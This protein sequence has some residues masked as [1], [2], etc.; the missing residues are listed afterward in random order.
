MKQVIYKAANRLLTTEDK[1]QRLYYAKR[2]DTTPLDPTLVLYETRDGNSIVDSPLA[3]FMYL[4][5][6]PQ[7][8]QLKHVW[9]INPEADEDA[10]KTSLP[11]DLLTKVRFVTRDTPAYFDAI[12]SA[13]YLINNSTFESF[14][15]KRPGQVYINTWHGTPLKHMGFDTNFP[16]DS[17]KNVIRNLLMAD[18]ILSPNAHTSN[19]FIDGYRLR[20]NYPGEI[21]E[22]G[23]PRIDRTLNSDPAK[24][25]AALAKDG[26]KLE[27]GKPILLYT[28]TW[29]GTD[30]NSASDDI[31]Q[32]IKEV[33]TIT[34][35]FHDQ[36]NVLVKVHPFAYEN[37][38]NDPQVAGQLVSNYFD[39][40]E[41]LAV[42]DVLI[43]DYSSIFFDFM[44]TDK[45]I[46]F[47]A[48][49]KDLYDYSRGMY[50]DQDELPG[51]TAENITQLLAIIG[52][53]AA[54]E[55]PYKDKY[56]QMKAKIVPYD[57]GDATKRYVDYI[58]A[59]TPSDQ[60]TIRQV[61]STKQK[62]LF[63]AG[64]MRSNG[65]TT[66]FLNLTSNLDY[67]KYDVT[68][69]S[70][71]PNNQ[72]SRANIAAVDPHV[73]LMFRFGNNIMTRQEDDLD[74]YF[75]ANGVKVSERDKYPAR[76]YA[77]EMQRLTAN[78]HFDV[79]IDFSGYSYF[80]GR[81][82][83]G[84]DA[85]H[86]VA[87]MHNDLWADAHREVDGKM[88][89]LKDLM[90]MFSLYYQFDKMLSVS[91][92][93]RDVNTK[94]LAA[95]IR[96]EQM[97]YVLNTINIKR[98]LAQPTAP[99]AE[100]DLVVERADLTVTTELT[101]PLYENISA[102]KT[103]T[104]TSVTIPANAAITQFASFT[105]GEDVYVKVAIAAQYVG[106]I[107]QRELV[108]APLRVF[109]V[110]P[111]MG[112]G[113]VSRGWWK[114][115]YTDIQSGAQPLAIHALARAFMHQYLLITALANTSQGDYY[116]VSYLGK[117]LGWV[118]KW[119]LGRVHLFASWSPLYAY[120]AMRQRQLDR[121][122]KVGYPDSVEAGEWYFT[123]G[124]TP[125]KVTIWTAPPATT[126]ATKLATLDEYHD[127]VFSATEIAT[128]GEHQYVTLLWKG[129][130]LGVVDLTGLKA[131]TKAEYQARAAQ[132]DMAP[133][134]LPEV[135]LAGQ[136][137][138]PFE[139]HY[140]NVVNMG[141]LSPEKNQAA[142]LDGFA[143]FVKQQPD[144][145]LYLMGKGPLADDLAKQLDRLQLR[146]KVFLLGHID[147]PYQLMKQC[148]LFILPSLYEGQP[149][150]LL[151]A[152]TL[153]MRVLA[154]KIPANVQ[155]VGEDERYGQLIDGTT[156]AAIA[157]ALQRVVTTPN[158]FTPFDYQAY[159][160]TAV[161]NFYASIKF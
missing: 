57:D 157:A 78:L 42:V 148:D 70:N 110:T 24:V 55:A 74:R 90:G 3:M 61:D 146:G 99:E 106:W 30:V 141:R 63:Y 10:I 26:V 131:I 120:F 14:F 117:N 97:D 49:D 89:I 80:W 128:V 136:Q 45:P 115:I 60:I 132:P 91:P 135:D 92:M 7:Y 36:Y 134:L 5:T 72:D 68:L 104:A 150:V 138:M 28:P 2:F 140:F 18:Y 144:S 94:K 38:K 29:K 11:A 100:S 46:I 98:I 84:A 21:L 114:P 143:Q 123:T 65:I 103:G 17:S 130:G 161:E 50:F 156:P 108:A 15:T 83:L 62:L 51:P 113:T 4:A 76:G 19:I 77:R 154:S 149:M 147:G 122:L 23:Y 52:D 79:A 112:A 87:F 111:M 39:P 129:R 121:T 160:T 40:N 20:G 43:T 86:R 81:H 152:L 85:A 153:G 95:Y 105:Q 66:S 25:L 125:A 58:F 137:V 9:V 88:P 93:T 151:E 133:S 126:D 109:K 8:A 16:A 47:Y 32:I 159:N 59:G 102:I 27:P 101:T 33:Q 142:L 41:L 145:R 6:Q 12:L 44:V 64:G 31:A 116:Q 34:A 75:M 107:S 56:A 35:K 82:I 119:V 13:K 124:K 158:T 71:V 118:D 73:R 67:T 48:W 53:L 1:K 96:P 69:L 37:I 22:S 127:E 139:D 155:V 54:Q